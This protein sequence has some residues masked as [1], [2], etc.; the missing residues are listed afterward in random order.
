MIDLYL[1]DLHGDMKD[2]FLSVIIG[3]KDKK[4]L[5]ALE[6]GEDIIIGE[7]WSDDKFVVSE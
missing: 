6:D 2:E 3:L 4:L 7:V 5:K 1:R